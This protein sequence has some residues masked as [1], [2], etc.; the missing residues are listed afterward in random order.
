MTE[1]RRKSKRGFAAMPELKRRNIASMGGKAV[2]EQ[3]LGHKW[4]LDEAREAGRRG[5]LESQRKRKAAK[6]AAQAPQHIG[7]AAGDPDLPTEA[8]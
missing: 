7:T 1:G 8:I 4:S 2:H 3:G 6:E 5:G